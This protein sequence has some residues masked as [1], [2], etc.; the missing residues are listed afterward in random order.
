VIDAVAGA[1]KGKRAARDHPGGVAGDHRFAA[2]IAI[3]MGG[4]PW[5]YLLGPD[6]SL[7]DR[8]HHRLN[9]GVALGRAA[10]CRH[11]P[12]AWPARWLHRPAPIVTALGGVIFRRWR[13]VS[14]K[15]SG[16]SLFAL[17]VI[18]VGGAFVQQF[19]FAAADNAPPEFKARAISFVLAGGIITAII[20]RRSS[21]SP[22]VCWRPV[23]FAGSFAAASA[24]ACGGAAILWCCAYRRRPSHAPSRASASP[25]ARGD[26]RA[27]ALRRGA[28]L[29]G[30][31][32]HADE[33]RHDR[34][35]AGHGRLRLL[36]GR[37]D[38]R[39]FLARDG[40]VRAELLHRPLIHASARSA[41]SPS[42]ALLIGCAV[43]ALSGM[44]LWQ[45]WTCADP[46]RL[47]W[48]FGFIGATAMVADS[49]FASEKGKVQGFHDFV[50]FGSVALPR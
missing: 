13:H 41:S 6:K 17:L 30:R 14:V 36:A 29:R 25:P 3:S 40:D 33:L 2:P 16:C 31:S 38:A 26:R 50:L 44:Q 24:R 21:S 9:I 10:G 12:L 19:R 22:R 11:H 34:R 7:C 46:A 43:V 32:L 45:F 8:A 39:H 28:D 48:N 23:T 5:Q 27:A 49:Y 35:A 42:A 37:G 15:H 47:G 20:G 1:S 18:G 4:L